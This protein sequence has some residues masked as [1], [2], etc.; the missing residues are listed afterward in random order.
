MNPENPDAPRLSPRAV[1]AIAFAVPAVALAVT[2]LVAVPRYRALND[3]TRQLATTQDAI[4]LKSR[5]VEQLRNLPEGPVIARRPATPDEPVQFLRELNRVAA[6]CGVRITSYAATSA[7]APSPAA[8][9]QDQ[10]SFTAPGRAGAAGGAAGGPLPAGTTPI[11]LQLSAEGDFT[12]MALFFARLEAYPRLVSL[13]GVSMRTGTYPGLNAQFRLTRYTGA[14]P[15]PQARPA[16][17]P[18]LAAAAPAPAGAPR[19]R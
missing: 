16:A 7:P 11:A 15:E 13:S 17:S 3:D 19:Y 10:P 12:S 14:A 1:R 9:P 6:F 2:A 5:E 8:A 4:S 18:R